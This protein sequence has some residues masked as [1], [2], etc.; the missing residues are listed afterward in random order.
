MIHVT[1]TIFTFG[2]IPIV[3][4]PETQTLEPGCYQFITYDDKDGVSREYVKNFVLEQKR[5][6]NFYFAL[7]YESEPGVVSLCVTT[8]PTP[9]IQRS[10]DLPSVEGVTTNPEAGRHYVGGHKNFTFT[11]TFTGAPL[12]V[13]ATGFYSHNTIDLDNTAR[14]L[15]G[16]M[17]EYTIRQVVEP[18]TIFI[19]PAVGNDGVPGHRVWAHKDVL[20]ISSEKEDVVSIYNMTGV[21]N[22]KIDI[23]EGMS[24]FTLEKGIYVVTLKDGSVYRIIIN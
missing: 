2:K 15:G 13:T 1:G 8:F 19:G 17:Y 24:R 12:K 6:G 22:K 21:L 14:S 7:D 23:P 9:D 18:W 4:L 20:Y 11:A 3:V 10:V 16:N 5:Y